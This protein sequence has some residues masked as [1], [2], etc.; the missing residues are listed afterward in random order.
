MP[1]GAHCLA[2]DPRRA[3]P[4]AGNSSFHRKP[5]DNLRCCNDNDSQRLLSSY[6]GASDADETVKIN[7]IPGKEGYGRVLIC[8]PNERKFISVP[9]TTTND[10]NVRDIVPEN[11]N[12]SGTIDILKNNR[13]LNL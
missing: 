7:E 13:L 4:S 12:A 9:L 5:V 1:S 10:D 8:V 3:A 2:G 11:I 6:N